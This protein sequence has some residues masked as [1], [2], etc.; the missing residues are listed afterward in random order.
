MRVGLVASAE[1]AE[2]LTQRE[3]RAPV[4]VEREARFEIR[5][6]FSPKLLALAECSEDAQQHRVLVV[7]G[8]PTLGLLDLARRVR[9]PAFAVGLDELGIPLTFEAPREDF[10]G[11]AIA[12]QLQEALRRGARDRRQRT[13]GFGQPT[14]RVAQARGIV[15]QCTQLLALRGDSHLFALCGVEYAALDQLVDE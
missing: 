12:A 3:V 4:I 6:C 11:L 9:K 14:P 10:P 2:H 8:E 15:R 5:L 13:R 7:T 1:T